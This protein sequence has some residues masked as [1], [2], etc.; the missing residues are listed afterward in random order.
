MKPITGELIKEIAEQLDCGF[1]CYIHKETGELITLPDEN[2]HSGMDMEFWAG[3]ME[4]VEESFGDYWVVKPP[5]SSDSFRMMEDFAYTLPESE[6]LRRRLIYALSQ[7]KPFRQFKFVID[8]SGPFRQQWF[9]FK[10]IQMQKW[11]R[12][13]LAQYTSLED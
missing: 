6:S 11:V 4:K 2:H 5:K 3:D 13:N 1:R 12:E 7:R 9:D 10:D 8:N